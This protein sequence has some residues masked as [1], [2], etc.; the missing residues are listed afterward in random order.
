VKTNA[1]RTMTEVY[2][3]RARTLREVAMDADVTGIPFVGTP[4]S[5]AAEMAESMAEIGGDGFLFTE[6]LSRR[7][8]T[9][10]T[11]GLVPALQRRGQ[12]RR[13]YSHTTLRQTLMEF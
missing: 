7:T 11:D 1:S 8:I 6:P 4:D 3:A 10:I 2:T 12:T 5:V 9:E 13:A